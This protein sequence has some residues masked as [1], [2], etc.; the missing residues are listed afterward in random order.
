MIERRRSLR[1]DPAYMLAVLYTIG[2]LGVVF[3]V[4][5]KEIPKDSMPVVQQLISI[6]SM[7]QAAIG[8]FYY[9]ASKVLQDQRKGLPTVDVAGDMNVKG[10]VK[11]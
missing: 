6:M 8:G 7:I 11:P 9:G 1:N 2:F 4:I 10:D 3:V 5:L